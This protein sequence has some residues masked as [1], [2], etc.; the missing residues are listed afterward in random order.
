MRVW[1]KKKRIEN[2]RKN[3]RKNTKR[4]RDKINVIRKTRNEAQGS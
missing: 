2:R 3:K 1:G 4:K